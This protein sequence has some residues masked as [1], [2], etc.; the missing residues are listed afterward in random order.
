MSKAYLQE[1]RKSSPPAAETSAIFELMNVVE[2]T[3]R[4]MDDGA[5]GSMKRIEH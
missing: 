3:N 1:D 4:T 5:I 2:S